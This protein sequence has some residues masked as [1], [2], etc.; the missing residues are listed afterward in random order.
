[1]SMAEYAINE[2]VERLFKAYRYAMDTAID[3]ARGE[4]SIEAIHD[5]ALAI[6]DEINYVMDAMEKLFNA[7][8][9]NEIRDKMMELNEEYEKIE[10]EQEL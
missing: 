5:I 9:P 2:V 7:K 8:I 3:I 6:A 4:Y 1:M 10:Q